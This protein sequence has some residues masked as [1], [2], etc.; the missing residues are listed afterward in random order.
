MESTC[1]DEVSFC[2]CILGGFKMVEF[3]TIE[4]RK[5]L[6]LHHKGNFASVFI[7]GGVWPSMQAFFF[8]VFCFLAISHYLQLDN[9]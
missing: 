1:F 4:S 5:K 6:Q 3:Y 2:L 8:L 9:H 7:H